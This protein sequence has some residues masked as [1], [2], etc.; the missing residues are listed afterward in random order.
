[1]SE[2]EKSQIIVVIINNA[3]QVIDMRR[4]IGKSEAMASPRAAS[5]NMPPLRPAVNDRP[6]PFTPAGHHLPIY[7]MHIPRSSGSSLTAFL[8]QIYGDAGVIDRAETVLPK[9]VNRHSTSLAS[10]CVVGQLPLI[11]WEMLRGTAA[12]RRVTVLRD[13]WARLVSHINWIDGFNNGAPLPDDKAMAPILRYLA[14]E[15]TQTDF[16]SRYSLARFV[17]LLK[18]VEMGFN[19]LQTR[20]LLTGSMSVMVKPLFGSDVDRAVQNLEG[21][22]I[23]GLCEDQVSVRRGLSH[24]LGSKVTPDIAF[25][26]RAK[27]QVLNPRNDL[28]REMLEPLIVADQEL[29]SRARSISARLV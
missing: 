21:F 29:Y 2:G 15:V 18:P 12:Y 4:W 6:V 14:D 28:A 3:E 22:A 19:N 27:G 10:D 13:P 24:L 26:G 11:R 23:V 20:M 25:E 16:T 9:L 7:F 1:M 8:R 17:R 5:V